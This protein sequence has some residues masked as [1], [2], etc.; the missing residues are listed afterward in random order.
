MTRCLEGEEL[1][2][3]TIGT[4]AFSE[5]RLDTLQSRL[6]AAYKGLHAL[7]ITSGAQDFL[8]AEEIGVANYFAEK[9]DIHHIFPRAWCEAQK[10][11]RARWNTAVNKT[12]LSGRTNRKIGGRAP[13]KYTATLD[14]E[15]TEGGVSLDEILAG[16]QITPEYLRTDDFDEFYAARKEA[17]LK[18][19]EA[20]MEKSALRD[21]TGDLSDY[22]EE[23]IDDVG[24]NAD[25]A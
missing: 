8:T 5:S 6:S 12:A 15:T 4:A 23:D 16:H 24:E 19:I 3:R 20:A 17:L 13:S 7:L 25:A 1:V 21:G 14:A 22:N 9:F 2:P 10:I 18:L 11:S